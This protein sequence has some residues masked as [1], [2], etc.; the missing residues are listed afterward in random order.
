MRRPPGCCRPC[1]VGISWVNSS[2]L[3][4]NGRHFTDDI[5]KHIFLNEKFWI[6]NKLSWKYV[7]WGLV[8]IMSAFGS[9]NGLTPSMRQAIIWTIAD[10]VHRHIYGAL[11]GDELTFTIKTTVPTDLVSKIMVWEVSYSCSLVF[12]V[13]SVW[14]KIV[15]SSPAKSEPFSV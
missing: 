14:L 15:R 8:D 12:K 1:T 2:P 5:F 13:L 6:S 3:G 7:P 11:E 10:P 4:Q 9:D